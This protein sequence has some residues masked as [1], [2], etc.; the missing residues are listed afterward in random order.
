M[1]GR[2][3]RPSGDAKRAPSQTYLK[4]LPCYSL[5]QPIGIKPIFVSGQIPPPLVE[6]GH[7]RA[8]CACRSNSQCLANH[9]KTKQLRKLQALE[10]ALALRLHPPGKPWFDPVLRP[11]PI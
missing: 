11:C 3:P 8:I 1:W 10:P 9:L 4:H 6:L 5:A 7:Q 2:P